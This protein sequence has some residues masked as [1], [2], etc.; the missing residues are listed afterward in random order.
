M[1]APGRSGHD[2]PTDQSEQRVLNYSFDE[3]FKILT[4]GLAAYNPVTNA[5]DRVQMSPDGG[6]KTTSA[7]QSARYDLQ[8]PVYYLGSAPVGAAE[9]DPVWSVTKID[10]TTNPYSSKVVQNIAW[11]GRTGATYV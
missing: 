9:A 1:S 10:M 5:M 3:V 6:I 4:V 11:T 8:D 7:N 2:T